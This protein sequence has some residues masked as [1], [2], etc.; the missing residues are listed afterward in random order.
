[1]LHS[2]A[3]FSKF[4][5][6]AV[7][8]ALY[9]L[10]AAS[11]ARAQATFGTITG[12]VTDSTSARIAGVE[13]VARQVETNY[14]YT[15]TSNE[16]GAYS[17]PELREGH[18]VLTARGQGFKE[19]T[20]SDI[21]LAARDVRRIDIQLEVGDVRSTIE[22]S[23]GGGSVIETETA[24]V[25]DM[26]TSEVMQ[27]LP[28]NTRSPTALLTMTSGVFTT[29]VNGVSTTRY[30]GSRTGEEGY[31]LDGI[32][33]GNGIDAG[34]LPAASFMESFQEM[35]VD[36]SNNTADIG[37][38]GQ[39]TLVTKSGGNNLHGSAFDYYKTN[40]LASRNP[41]S[42]TKTLAVSHDFGGSI[43][44]PVFLPKLYNGRNRTFFYFS[45]EGQLGGVNHDLLNPTVAPQSWRNGDFTTAGVTIYDP[46]AAVKTPFPGNIIPTSRLN[47]VS[48]KIQNIFFPLPNQ[49]GPNVYAANNYQQV[50]NRPYDPNTM[51]TPRIDHRF[52]DKDAVYFR[53]TW[54][55]S[56]GRPYDGNIPTIG[57]RDLMVDTR[58]YAFSYTHILKPNL[59][60]E[61]TVGM[62][63]RPADRYPAPYGNAVDSEL[64]L[65]GLVAGIP[66]LHGIPAVS[67]SNLTMT[68]LSVQYTQMIYRSGPVYEFRNVVN[69]FI[70]H[71]SIKVGTNLSRDYW[72]M[73]TASP[74]LFGSLS[75]SNLFTGFTY[76]D[77]MLG[78]TTSSS[79]AY[80]PVEAH[81]RRTNYEFYGTD[82]FK[83]SPSLTLD[84]GLRYEIHTP[85]SD[86]DGLISAFGIGGTGSLIVPDAGLKSVSPV[87]PTSY[88]KI[89]TTSSQGLPSDAFYHTQYGNL[90]PRIGAAWRPFGANTVLRAGY[91]IFFDSVQIAPSYASTPFSVSVPTYTNSVSAPI[92]LPL[93]YPLT[94]GAL[95]SVSLPRGINPNL[96]TPYSMQYNARWST[97][98]GAPVSGSPSSLPTRGRASGRSTSTNRCRTPVYTST[99]RECFRSIRRLATRPTAPVINTPLVSSK[100][101]AV[102]ARISYTSSPIR[103]LAT[104]RIWRRA[105]H[106]KTPM[107]A[108]ANVACGS[109]FQPIV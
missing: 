96:K 32:G 16:T 49:G 101:R 26:K 71:H 50:M 33:F 48:Q 28:S 72:D 106:R 90:A 73:S 76:A 100:L 15:A 67:F 3:L 82:S 66:N 12:V 44:G 69:Y 5:S 56:W 93:V 79:I 34:S 47:P 80:P 53:Y 18:Y 55:R 92:T 77:F 104:S 14:R 41:F 83:V 88:I 13:V 36:I 31:T 40:G 68:G 57:Q 37:T 46:T 8:A 98:A 84:L 64:G 35:R 52:S 24:R 1:M 99:R 2:C 42:A 9:L 107:T 20:A 27:D 43:G 89:A 70:G 29:S 63:K 54:G 6:I 61:F 103:S 25:A 91:G 87:M 95:T 58:H 94:I 39:T 109:T 81:M 75:F 102:W 21:T 45:W 74:S 59:L 78:Y 65:Q 86:R 17:L 4:S 11:A 108:S 10:L 105:R 30:A 51:W 60:N 85:W 38:V 23:A 19:Y 62:V 97:S 7:L 22:V